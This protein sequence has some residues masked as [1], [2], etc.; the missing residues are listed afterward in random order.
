MTASEIAELRK[1][2][3]MNRREIAEALNVDYDTYRAWE[4]GRRRLSAI[5]E[6]AIRLL[7]EKRMAIKGK[8]EHL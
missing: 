4:N 1:Q 3:G 8:Q 7:A 5:G 2:L 6:T